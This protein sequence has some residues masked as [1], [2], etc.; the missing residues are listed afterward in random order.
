M[1]L[2]C[3]TQSRALLAIVVA[4]LLVLTAACNGSA[5]EADDPAQSP[6]GA[7]G[8]FPVTIEHQFG[9][10][11]IE[12]EPQSVV[13]V[14]FN[15]Q[16]FVLAL[17][18]EPVGVRKFLGYDAPNRPWA[19][20]SVRGKE[21]PTVGAEDIDFEKIASLQPD[22]IMAV[23]GFIEQAD[24]DKLSGIAPTVAQSDEYALGATPWQ[25][26]TTITGRA[27]GKEEE[28]AQL[29]SD[30]EQQ[31][32]TAVEENPD[33]AGKEARFALGASE[34][35][36]YSLGADDYRTGWL[37]ELGFTVPDTGGEV[38][39]ELIGQEMDA[40]VLVAEGVPSEVRDLPLVQNIPVVQEGRTVFLGEDFATDFAGALG[41]NSPLSIPAM[42]EI[43][44]PRL[45]A[46]TDGD[47]DSTPEPYPER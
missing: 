24:Y 8:V 36:T 28:A 22:L 12:S 5:S 16:D 14:G 30:V 31:F 19:P 1:R 18:V 40:D 33:F 10:T 20:E 4:T 23:N 15:E 32:A 26:Q 9:S 29:V 34:A 38:S 3:V 11:E 37:T 45:A 25:E 35:G 42:L 44:V 43:A 17:G 21:I 27:L 47:P 13:A 41:F 2:P 6:G 7:G 46:A 39:P